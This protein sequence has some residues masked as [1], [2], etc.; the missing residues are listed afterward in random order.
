MTKH[1]LAVFKNAQAAEMAAD[2]LLAAGV[3]QSE[4]S[5]LMDNNNPGNRIVVE[6]KSKAPEGAATGA[7]T[8]GA[9]GAVVAAVSAV[10]S[11]VI[12]GVGILAGPLV[13]AVA[14]AGV[15]AAAGGVA[16]GLIGLGIPEHEA[17]TYQKTI[18]EGGILL[19]VTVDGSDKHDVKKI[20]KDA[21]GHGVTVE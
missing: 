12:P 15:G 1:V 9:L 8:G 6:S 5:V 20:L 7:L 4:I 19:G 21:G 14:G 11:I 3:P 18:Q 13:A 16:G 10:G 2:R 17:K